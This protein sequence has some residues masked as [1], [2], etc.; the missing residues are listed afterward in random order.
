MTNNI[1]WRRRTADPASFCVADVPPTIDGRPAVVS[2]RCENVYSAVNEQR[3][4][5]F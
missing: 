5:A 1:V 2:C 3:T 4:T